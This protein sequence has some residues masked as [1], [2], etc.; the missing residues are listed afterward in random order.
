MSIVDLVMA[1]LKF[2]KVAL[3]R[4]GKNSSD[5]SSALIMIFLNGIL[6]G[7]ISMINGTPSVVGGFVAGFGDGVPLAGV[8]LLAFDFGLTLLVYLLLGFTVS[9]FIKMFGG[10]SGATSVLRIIGATIIWS[11]LASI[12]TIFI[13]QGFYLSLVGFVALLFGISA[14]SGKNIVIVFIAFILA[15]ILL[16]IILGL[17][18]VFL[19]FGLLAALM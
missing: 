14:Y 4:I 11:M 17:L 16:M 12:V 9:L 5:T 1:G 19:L 3:N 10:T 2:D 7:I 13:A 6:A 18:F 8:A 15:I